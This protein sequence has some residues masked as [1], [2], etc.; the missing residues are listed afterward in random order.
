M[1]KINLDTGTFIHRVS[2]HRAGSCR[3]WRNGRFLRFFF[4][5]RKFQSESSIYNSNFMYFWVK[6]L[7]NYATGYANAANPCEK[8]MS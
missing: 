6:L 1:V 4:L 7:K 8:K 3:L 2:Y 5:K